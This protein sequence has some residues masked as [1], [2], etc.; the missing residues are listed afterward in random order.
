M[1]S[2]IDGRSIRG[3]G[4]KTLRGNFEQYGLLSGLA[5]TFS[6]DLLNSPIRRAP[7]GEGGDGIGGRLFDA[8]ICDPPYGVREGLFVLGIRDVE[9]SPWLLTK[10]K[11]MYK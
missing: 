8:I 1:G 7:L 10:G 5:G 2:D 4:K 3:E 11:E 6:A 9:K